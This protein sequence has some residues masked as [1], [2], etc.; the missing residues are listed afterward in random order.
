MTLNRLRYHI[1]E[2]TYLNITAT[3]KKGSDFWNEQRGSICEVQIYSKTSRSSASLPSSSHMCKGKS[4][5][6]M[7]CRITT[8][9]IR[10]LEYRTRGKNTAVLYK[11]QI[12]LYSLY[13]CLRKYL[14][15]TEWVVIVFIIDSLAVFRWVNKYVMNSQN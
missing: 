8:V 13:L 11:A 15:L 5:D 12:S 4:A 7:P 2:Y 1:Y 6:G 10:I 9:R 3:N 14:F